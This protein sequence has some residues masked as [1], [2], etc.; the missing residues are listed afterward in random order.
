MIKLENV[1]SDFLLFPIKRE[2][3]LGSSFSIFNNRKT[4][5]GNSFMGKVGMPEIEYI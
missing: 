2:G 3:Y 4:T 5:H 1:F